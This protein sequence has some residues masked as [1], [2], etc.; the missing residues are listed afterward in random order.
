MPRNGLGTYTAPTGAWNPAI[1]GQ[2]ATAVD[3][4]TLL[5]DLIA[6]NT[7]SLSRDG[8]TPMSG[9][10]QMTGNRITGLAAGSA[11]GDSLRFEQ[12]FGQGNPVSLASAAT[13]DIGGQNT[14]AIEITGSTTITSLGIN[15]RGPRFLRFTSALTL[16]NS[17][18]LTLP[19]GVN[20]ITSTGSF[21]IAYPNLALNGWNVF[22]ELTTAAQVQT[23]AATIAVVTGTAT[24]VITTQT[25]ATP[26]VQLMHC[27]MTTA[28][29]G[30]AST[31]AS[32][33]D[34]A[35]ATKQ[36][37]S[38]GAKI[39]A[40]WYSG[41]RCI[42]VKDATPNWILLNPAPA[43]TPLRGPNRIINGAMTVDQRNSGAAV[44]VTA[45]QAVVDRFGAANTTGSGTLTV[46]QSNLLG[47]GRSLRATATTAI[48]SIALSQH[49]RP[50]FFIIEGANCFDL[51]NK[52]ITVSFAVETNWAGNLAFSVRNSAATRS[53]VTNIGV[54]AG[55]NIR[56]V[57]IPL[58]A[59]SVATN[60][61][62]AGLQ[63]DIGFCNT[64]TFQTATT[65]SWIAG[66]FINAISTQWCQTAGNFVNITQIQVKQETSPSPFDQQSIGQALAECKRYAQW[67]SVS[68]RVNAPG[69]AFYEF[70][71]AWPEMR[72]SP[73]AAGLSFDPNTLTANANLTNNTVIRQT[74]IGGSLSINA[75]ASG[76][77]YLLGYRS[78]LSAEYF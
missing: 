44:V 74:P 5:N 19:R 2:P 78:F 43:V 15:F 24:A 11:V 71:L 62:A 3:W 42:W 21:Y 47:Y 58:E 56:S 76:D 34:A 52:S 35:L 1:N 45:L 57:T 8:Q 39:D 4:T 51:N 10:L 14:V 27:T 54:S 46:Q 59:T 29:G 67:V 22:G 55:T 26:N 16:T 64:Q 70:P 68:A 36:Y 28:N 23:L 31:I 40:V 37:D 63:F 53:F 12:L 18:T 32:N 6:A 65:N 69:P 38:T 25:P 7:Q 60:D 77:T 73:S 33:G 30:A 48:T 20:E 41:Q 75:A 49:V 50:C 17:A 66:N 9:N 72:V 61:N 13:V